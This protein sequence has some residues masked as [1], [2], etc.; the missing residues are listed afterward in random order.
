MAE[1]VT[2][3]D[4]RRAVQSA[5]GAA[6]GLGAAGT[7]FPVGDAVGPA[8]D[9]GAV[10]AGGDVATCVPSDA[11]WVGMT[12]GAESP[13]PAA[14]TPTIA[15]EMSRGARFTLPPWSRQQHGQ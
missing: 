3:W 12:T 10:A 4:Q 14:S 2:G 7:G 1:I 11:A 8:P 9:G 5:A 13:Q 15:S 6:V